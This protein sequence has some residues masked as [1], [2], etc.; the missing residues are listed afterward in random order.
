M[1]QEMIESKESVTQTTTQQPKRKSGIVDRTL[2]FI[3]ESIAALFWFYV[4]TKLFIFDIDIFLFGMFSPDYAWLL[5]YRCLILLGIV[6]TFWLVTKN[7]HII[8]WTLYIFFYPVI[9]LLWK[10]PFFVFRQRSWSFVFAFFDAIISFFKSFRFS[11]ITV[12][13]FL[14]SST[15]IFGFSNEILLW[16][17]IAVL[18]VVISAVYIHRFVLVFKPAGVY[19]VYSIVFSGI[20]NFLSSSPAF[21][22]DD[23]MTSLSIE[24]LDENQVQKWTT[25]VQ[26]LVLHNRICL[27]VARKL[28]NYQRSGFII[29]SSVLTILILIAL[30]IFSFA[31]VNYG[32]FKINNHFFAFSVAPTFFTFFYFSFNT[33]L[34]NPIPDL[35]AVM[36][37][38]QT[39]SMIESSF[40]L[41]LIAIFV[42]L[43][44]SVRSQRQTDELNAAIWG[45]EEQ[46]IKIEGY[47]KSEYN[48]NSIEEAMVALRKLKSIL[49]DFLYK[50]TESIG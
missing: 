18:I 46:G 23:S 38:S 19:Q 11:F 43:V 7:K 36:P 42:S 34:F 27:F 41:F 32:L 25:N 47:I 10:I 9:V 16:L 21:A 28:K 1:N 20:G 45:L 14:I 44:L 2:F 3:R 17:A 40:A 13:F 8:L 49:T 39:I 6:A 29:V 4:I 15:I 33:L 26:T 30:T 22:L 35:V 5:N 48:L 37:I 12:S 50:V 24:N 31:V